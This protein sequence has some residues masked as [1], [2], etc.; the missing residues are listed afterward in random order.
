MM[1]PLRIHRRLIAIAAVSMAVP[2]VLALG[3]CSDSDSEGPTPVATWHDVYDAYPKAGFGG[4]MSIV[5]A[6]DRACVLVGYGSDMPTGLLLP[7]GYGVLEDP[8]RL[9]DGKGRVVAEAG[10]YIAGGGGVVAHD[11]TDPTQGS[12]VAHA[13]WGGC[14]RAELFLTDPDIRVLSFDY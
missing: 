9:V 7:P 5:M 11:S 6:D 8:L 1:R 4:E 2:A 14:P 3:A 10:Q 12:P 13:A